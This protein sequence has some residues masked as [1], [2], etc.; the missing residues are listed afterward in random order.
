MKIE[1]RSEGAEKEKERDKI[2]EG[3]RE[4]G[5]QNNNEK[6]REE[7]GDTWERRLISDALNLKG[8]K[9][10]FLWADNRVLTQYLSAVGIATGYW[11]DDRGVGV[12]ITVG[13]R[14][15]PFSKSSRP[16]LGPIQPP[17]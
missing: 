11:L 1:E 7:E 17:I 13:S 3:M 12:R 14:I 15:F 6:T 2:H 10:A 4:C 9:N 5:R 8:L 16:V